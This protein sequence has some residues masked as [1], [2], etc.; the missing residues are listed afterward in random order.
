MT[1][2]LRAAVFVVW[3]SPVHVCMYVCFAVVLDQHV[4]LLPTCIMPSCCMLTGCPVSVSGY[5]EFCV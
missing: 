2:V 4:C 1:Y 5:H 3:A